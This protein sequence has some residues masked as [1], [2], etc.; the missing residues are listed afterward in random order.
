MIS[1]VN[2][3][4]RFGPRVLFENISWM[5]TAQD[6][7]GL[8]GANGTG[9]STVMKILGGLETVDAGECTSQ[10]GVSAGYLPQDGLHLTGRTVF[11]E[12]LSV[13]DNLKDM[14][15]EME[16]LA[17]SLSD[18]DPA[19]EEYS[20]AAT[21][22]TSLDAQFRNRDGYA[23][24]AKVG[25]VLTGLGFPKEEWTKHTE[26]FSGGWRFT[27]FLPSRAVFS[28]SFRFS[29]TCSG[30]CATTQPRSSNPLRPARPPIW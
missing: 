8:V 12:C 18:L 24:E 17:R 29:M 9:K 23:L 3:S 13:F 21:R 7:V 30:A 6:R 25:S 20:A 22:Y 26:F 1:L 28:A 10:K 27:V 5:I 11:A 19:S 2:A 15:C 14:E 4:K 16:Q